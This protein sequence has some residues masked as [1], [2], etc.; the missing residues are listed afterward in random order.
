V[1]ARLRAAHAAG[2][3]LAVVTNQGRLTD[4]AGREAPEALLFRAKVARIAAAL[5]LPLTVYAACANDGWRKP[6]LGVWDLIVATAA[7]DAGGGGRPGP[8]DT[9]ASVFVGDA[10]GRPADHSDAD[11][12]FALNAGV[13]FATPEGYFLG[14]EG[15]EAPAHKFDPAQCLDGTGWTGV[16]GLVVAPR[17]RRGIPLTGANRGETW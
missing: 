7:D 4:A 17:L 11:Y 10:A 1:P 5:R 16:C 12:H 8:L 14:E 13:A 6:R 3:T 9:A 15:E 2:F